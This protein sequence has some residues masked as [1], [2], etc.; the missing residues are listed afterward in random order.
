M[1][2]VLLSITVVAAFILSTS[3]AFG[4]ASMGSAPIEDVAVSIDDKGTAHVVHVVQ[5][6]ATGAVHVEMISGT[7]TNFSVTDKNGNSVQYST[8]GQNPTTILLLPTKLETVLIKYDIDNAVTFD[9]GVWKWD[10]Y[11][12]SDTGFTDF[13]FPKSVKMIWANDRPVYIEGK[14]IRDHGNGVHLAYS[15]DEPTTMQTVQWE[16]KTFQVGIRTTSKPSQYVFD[17]STKAYAFNVDKPSYVTVIMPQALL[18]GPY[19][20]TLNG[21]ATLHTEFHKNGT[22]VWIGMNP[23]SS[24]TIQITG[25]TAVPE[26]P[27]FVPL[28]IAVSAVII[29]R[30]ANKLN[31]N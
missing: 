11:T 23:R 25:T 29:L 22:D 21:N 20:V 31:F 15:I 16:D 18:W 2:K 9:N 6:N 3:T 14:G 12:P 7:H 5:G 4:Q 10:Y 19:H 30:F 26:F 24:G 13:Y 8:I 17:Q 1:L 28:A 27:M